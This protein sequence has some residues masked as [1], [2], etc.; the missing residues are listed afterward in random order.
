MIDEKKIEEATIK[1]FRELSYDFGYPDEDAFK[2]G[3]SRGAE[4]AQEEY[5]KSLWHDGS[6][7]PIMRG[8]GQILVELNENTSVKHLWRSITTYESLCNKK[9]EIRRWAYLD[10]ILP[11]GGEE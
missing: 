3:F 9:G 2:A 4:W 10:D 6:E 8:H 7:K 11:K 5:V 1:C